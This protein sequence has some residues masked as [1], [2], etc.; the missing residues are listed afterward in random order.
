MPRPKLGGA[1]FIG[2]ESELFEDI[3]QLVI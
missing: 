3:E 2:L 1:I